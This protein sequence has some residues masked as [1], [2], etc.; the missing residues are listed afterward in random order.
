MRPRLPE[1]GDTVYWYHGADLAGEPH[2]AFVSAVG[3][4]TCCLNVLSQTSYGFRIVDGVRHVADP[5][6]KTNVYLREAGGWEARDEYRA[7]KRPAETPKSV[8]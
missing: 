4:E 1:L 7:R 2:V 5:A 8:K 6:L 3:N